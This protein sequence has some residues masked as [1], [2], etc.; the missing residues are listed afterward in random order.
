MKTV[1]LSLVYPEA[2]AGSYISGGR[3][4]VARRFALQP[5]VQSREWTGNG[6]FLRALEPQEDGKD[7]S[8]ALA[9]LHKGVLM[10]Q[11]REMIPN[12]G[13]CRRQDTALGKTGYI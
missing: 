4:G 13:N 11:D 6:C 8:S 1:T 5:P 10:R 12:L 2:W 7:I 9:L 3:E